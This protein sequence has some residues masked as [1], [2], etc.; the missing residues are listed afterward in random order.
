MG[1]VTGLISLKDALPISKTKYAVTEYDAWG[2][3]IQKDDRIRVDFDEEHY[4]IINNSLSVSYT[5]HLYDVATG[6]WNAGARQYDPETKRFTSEDP[7]KGNLYQPITTVKY[8]YANDNPVMYADYNGRFATPTFRQAV[9]HGAKAIVSGIKVGVNAISTAV[10][11]FNNV[12]ENIPAP[13]KA[14]FI[15]AATTVAIASGVAPVEVAM[16]LARGAMIGGAMN[17]GFYAA[18]NLIAGNRIDASG[19]SNQF[20]KGAFD[21]MVFASVEIAAKG[22]QNIRTNPEVFKANVESFSNRVAYGA[23]KVSGKAKNVI[24]KAKTNISNRRLDLLDETGE[25]DFIGSIIDKCLG[26][27]G[28]K[29]S[30]SRAVCKGGR[31]YAGVVTGGENLTNAKRMMHGSQGNVGVI[32]KEIAD[33][34]RGRQYSNFDAFREDFWKT[35]ADSSYASEFSNSNIGRM[36]NGRAPK[37]VLD[38]TYGQ[39]ESYILHHKT[40]IHA[41]G[42]VYN[43]DN[44]AIVTPRMHQEI[45]DKAY[46]FGN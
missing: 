11:A 34:M 37:V 10:E 26:K 27:I 33:K 28:E 20:V 12:Y 24:S 18:N 42:E 44:L 35:V 43:L 29:V 4:E 2:R 1:S 13:A 39:L 19:C 25:S 23:E 38:Q 9:C 5:G 17:T 32:P 41:G 45:L 31:N 22:I 40:P 46:H 7:E 30:G 14:V 3:V 6:W 15:V 21:G 8:V 16:T 36:R